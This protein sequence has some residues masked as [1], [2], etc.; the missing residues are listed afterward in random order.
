[1]EQY[2]Q[3]S[4][5]FEEALKDTEWESVF[6]GSQQQELDRRIK[7]QMEES[8]E[9]LDRSEPFEAVQSEQLTL[10]LI[11]QAQEGQQQIRQQVQEQAQSIGQAERGSSKID[12][13]ESE[14]RGQRE[15]RQKIMNSLR[16]EVDEKFQESKDRY[17][18]EL[19]QR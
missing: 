12:I 8:V 2:N 4:R 6:R 3:M 1:M 15:R 13:V 9:A 7:K 10:E 11:Q 18:E 19:L 17:F 16:Q 5:N 14:G